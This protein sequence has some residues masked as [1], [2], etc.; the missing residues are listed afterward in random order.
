MESPEARSGRQS[1]PPIEPSGFTPQLAD[2]LRPRIERLG[3]LGEFFKRAAH[4]PEALLSFIAFTED[5]KRA[6]PDNLTEV[7][8]LTVANRLKN[9]YERHQHE[10]LCRKLGF[11]DEWIRGASRAG[12]AAALPPLERSVQALVIAVIERSGHGVTT[13]LAAVGDTLGPAQVMAILM[14]IGRY[15]THSLIVNALSLTPPVPSIFAAEAG[16][17]QPGGGLIRRPGD[18]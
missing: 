11:T 3:Y 7:V 6:L 8:A 9:D 12:S 16:A 4:Q 18:P 15:T 13:E 2:A 1:I 5:L 17:P 14:L 10:R